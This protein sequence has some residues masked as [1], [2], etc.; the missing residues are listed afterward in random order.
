MIT[1]AKHAPMM[2]L[3]VSSVMR[4][5][6]M[7]WMMALQA[8]KRV[9]VTD[10]IKKMLAHL[11]SMENRH[12]SKIIRTWFCKILRKKIS[13]YFISAYHFWGD[14][15]INVLSF[16][17]ISKQ[18]AKNGKRQPLK[19]WAIWMMS[20]VS[21]LADITTMPTEIMPIM[22]PWWSQRGTDFSLGWLSLLPTRSSTRKI[23]R[24]V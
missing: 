22:M 4:V 10:N 20:T 1:G 9:T 3:V 7:F 16:M 8:K 19:T 12:F 21:T 24:I 18:V 6:K 17:Q 14:F 11:K 2:N 23:V 5:P 13:D 15:S